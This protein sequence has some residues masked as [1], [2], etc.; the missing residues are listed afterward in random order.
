[1][2]SKRAFS[3]YVH[4]PFCRSKCPYCAFYSFR[5][6][7]GEMERWTACVV[8]EL[9]ALKREHLE[10]AVLST[11]YFGGGT[12]SY[13]P[14]ELWRTLCRALDA[15]SKTADCEFT[16]EAN[17]ENL[18]DE[19][20][21]IMRECGVNRLSIGVESTHLKFLKLMGRPHTFEEAKE[22]VELAKKHGFTN[23]SCDLI[24]GLP[25]ETLEDVK[26]D[27]V[28]LL[29]LGVPHLSTYCLSVNPGT[30]W[31]N[32]G[33]KEMDDGEAAD[34]YDLILNEFRKAGYKRY[35]VSNFAKP[36]YESRHNLVYWRD[37]EYYAAGLGASGYLNGER[38]TFTK[39]LLSYLKG[40]F[41]G[42]RETLSSK[43]KKEEFFLTHLRLEEGFLDE[44][45]MKRFG[46]SFFDEYKKQFESLKS[47][48]LLVLEGDGVHCTDKGF[49]LLDRVLISLF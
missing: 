26:Q 24:Y 11:I 44:D 42:E 35:E 39:N 47:D 36:G 38:F 45:Y 6:R 14:L 41:E 29:S 37:E 48:G 17:P 4:V 22:K 7:S 27:V 15:L 2:E 13:L 9:A 8:K 31:H 23:I 28:G 21:S 49:L 16:V 20:L 34:Q 30:V 10:D 12:P 43:D 40:S 33:Y 1:M 3:L 25:T 32:K 18:D 46:V 19:K 5:P